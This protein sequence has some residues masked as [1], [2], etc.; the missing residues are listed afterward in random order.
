MKKLAVLC[1]GLCHFSLNA[2][3][4]NAM[5][6]F[7]PL[8]ELRE[9]KKEDLVVCYIKKYEEHKER[10]NNLSRETNGAITFTTDNKIAQKDPNKFFFQEVM[11]L[12]PCV[13]DML[14]EHIEKADL[15]YK[16]PR[17]K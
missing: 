14:G 6:Y 7:T 2:M 11:K 1:L 17:I 12:T 10:V 16:G 5:Q 9:E 8:K 13:I 3:L 4:G 15:E